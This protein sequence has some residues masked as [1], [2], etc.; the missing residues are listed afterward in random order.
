MSQVA[1]RQKDASKHVRSEAGMEKYFEAMRTIYTNYRFFYYVLRNVKIKEV[2][3][4]WLAGVGF[5]KGDTVPTLFFNSQ[6]FDKYKYFEEADKEKKNELTYEPTYEE[7]A[8]VIVHELLHICQQIFTRQSKFGMNLQIANIAHDILINR[9][10]PALS[11][12][13]ENKSLADFLLHQDKYPS[14]KDMKLDECSLPMVYDAIKED[15]ESKGGQGKIDLETLKK[16]IEN[17]QVIMD[18]HGEGDESGDGMELSEEAQAYLEDLIKD[19]AKKCN[20]DGSWGHLPGSLKRELDTLMKP[21]PRWR[22]TLEHFVQ[23]CRQDEAEKTW[24]RLSRRYGNRASGRKAQNRPNLLVIIDTSGSIGEEDFNLFSSYLSFA[25]GFCKSVKVVFCDTQIQYCE[26]LHDD[27][28]S[29]FPKSILGGGGTDMS[30]GFE[31]GKKEKVDGVVILTDLCWGEPV[32]TYGIPTLAL[33]PA[34]YSIEGN[35]PG[36]T[37]RVHIE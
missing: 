11:R 26:E 13:G 5:C 31:Y 33:V 32:N 4:V 9:E 17:G 20:S 35:G 12:R 28:R 29:K 27:Q 14:L 3:D 8:G 19:S 25:V 2:G 36:I 37:H 6:S 34:R 18:Y 10:I 23:N 16:M 22:S 24:K 21:K 15:M 30:P 1:F 7:L